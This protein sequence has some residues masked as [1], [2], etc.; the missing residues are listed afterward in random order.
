MSTKKTQL[1][2]ATEE[3]KSLVVLTNQKIIELGAHTS[4]LY[5]A[6]IMI[7]SQFDK[8]RNI[9]SD[10]QLEYQKIKEICLSWKQHVDKIEND[11]ETAA[12]IT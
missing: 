7:Q 4:G 3:V 5:N 8:I 1:Q 6:L 12:K 11:Y 9:P 2:I 10:K